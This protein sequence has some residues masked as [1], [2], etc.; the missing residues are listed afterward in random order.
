MV[1]V[2][3]DL[4]GGIG[5]RPLVDWLR[6]SDDCVDVA[7]MRGNIGASG[8]GVERIAQTLHADGNGP[9]IIIGHSRGGQLARVAALRNSELVDRLIT[10]GAALGRGG[11][12]PA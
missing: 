6:D 4:D 10:V 11:L 2:N 7:K 1:L 5:S 12:A 9:A 8:T 3:G